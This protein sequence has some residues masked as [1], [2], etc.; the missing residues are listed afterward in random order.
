MTQPDNAGNRERVNEAMLAIKALDPQASVRFSEYTGKWYVDA[1]TEVG[2]G[3]ILK[4]GSEHRD[5]P[6]EA[7][8]AY[9]A[10]LIAIDH[11]HYIVASPWGERR[12]YRWNGAAFA[13]TSPRRVST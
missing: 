2:D 3:S 11:E 9:F 5:H 12:E 4:G 8:L 13:E 7:V 10:Y 1:R 6:G